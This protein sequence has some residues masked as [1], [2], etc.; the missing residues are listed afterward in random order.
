MGLRNGVSPSSYQGHLDAQT[1]VARELPE[2]PLAPPPSGT[3]VFAMRLLLQEGTKNSP[4]KL[5]NL[6]EPCVVAVIV[7]VVFGSTLH[8]RV[9][10]M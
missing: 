10:E 9:S 2:T 6:H 5:R 7:V 8:V 3:S 4:K 1:F